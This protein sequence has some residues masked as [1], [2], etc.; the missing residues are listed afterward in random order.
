MW[1]VAELVRRLSGEPFAA[2]VRKHIFEPLDLLD[3]WIGIPA[4][5]FR[6]Y[7]ERIA[8]IE[9]VKGSGTEEW[10]TWGRPTGGGFG[11]IR[12]LGRYYAALMQHRILSAPVVD[13][14][15][16]RQLCGVYDERLESTVD[17]GLGFMLGSSYRGHGFG[18]HASKRA[19]G[20]GGRQWCVAF[21]DPE[22]DL[23]VAVYWNGKPDVDAHADRLHSLLGALY[24]DLGLVARGAAGA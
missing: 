5:R 7:G 18:P 11:P 14:M 3:S 10:V 22:H 4:E 16:T 23:A 8:V 24:S 21:G 12:D 15:T 19:F 20:H 1:V 2:F 6:P 17:R 9:G 13:A